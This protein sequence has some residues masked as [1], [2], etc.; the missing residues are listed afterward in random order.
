MCRPINAAEMQLLLKTEDGK[1]LRFVAAPVVEVQEDS[2]SSQ[3]KKQNG[4]KTKVIVNNFDNSNSQVG[5]GQKLAVAK[6]VC[7]LYK[8]FKF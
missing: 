6:M 1:V 8:Y 5:Q 3:T 4:T 7:I 2:I